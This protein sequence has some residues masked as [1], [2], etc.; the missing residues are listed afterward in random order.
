MTPIRSTLAAWAVALA[1]IPCAV[2]QDEG[3]DPVDPMEQQQRTRE[4]LMRIRSRM[5]EVNE[6]LLQGAGGAQTEQEAVGAADDI[7]QL[8]LQAESRSEAVIRGIDELIEMANSQPPQSGGGGGQPNQ[9]PQNDPNS[10]D[11]PRRQK[12]DDP[13]QLQEQPQDSQQQDSQQQQQEQ[14]GQ[15]PDQPP[16]SEQ[17]PREQETGN[18]PPEGETG[19]F[20]NEDTAGRWGVL[21]P[22]QAEDLQRHNVEEFPQRYRQYMERYL[23]RVN[24]SRDR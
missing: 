2:A 8:L 4:L 1:M 19:A 5:K 20:T 10:Q 15:H 24:R 13:Q 21:P 14:G 7:K 3:G 16:S 12:S 23:K 6:L 22:K 9:P 11:Q 17:D 18:P